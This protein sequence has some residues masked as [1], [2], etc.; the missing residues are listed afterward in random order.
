MPTQPR[1]RMISVVLP[2]YNEAAV[3]EETLRR[4]GAAL[5][6][7][8]EVAELIVVDD[9][10]ADGTAELA[11]ALG[12]PGRRDRL[13]V[14][15]LRRPKGQGLATAVLA[16]WAEARGEIVGVMDADLQHPPEALAALARAMRSSGADIAIASRYVPGGGQSDRWGWSR[17]L[18]SAAATHLAASVMPWTF[19]KV[20]DPMSGMFLLRRSLLANLKLRPVGYKVLLEVLAK[21]PYRELVEVPYTFEARRRG[22]SK[23]GG[24]Q[25]LEYLAH[26]ARLA[27]STGMVAGW[28][29]YGL[30]GLL[31]GAVDVGLVD[32]LAGRW[33]RPLYLAVPAAIQIAVVSNFLWHDLGTFSFPSAGAL[34]YAHGVHRFLRYEKTCLCGAALNLSTTLLLARYGVPMLLAAAVGVVAGGV[35]NF[36]LNVPRIWKIWSSRPAAPG[37]LGTFSAPGVARG[38]AQGSK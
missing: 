23:L 31:G 6:S 12:D 17:R 29:R 5:A 20:H 7:A 32:L 37:P 13:P 34:R 9:S 10:S 21:V 4:A 36:S 16:G 28:V 14:R 2:T 25:S 24:R 19:A 15:V 30:V 33:K 1:N 3:I 27:R 18:M 38:I 11:E 8:G 35:W 22:V 26:L